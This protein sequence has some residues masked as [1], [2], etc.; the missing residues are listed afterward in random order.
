MLTARTVLNTNVATLA[1]MRAHLARVTNLSGNDIDE[2]ALGYFALGAVYGIS[3]DGALAQCLHETNNLHFGGQVSASQHNMA[4]I[5]ATNDGAAGLAWPTWRDGITAHYIHLLAWCGQPAGDADPRIREVKAAIR[6]L[7]KVITWRD[8]GGRWAVPGDGYA[9]AIERHWQ[10]IVNETGAA[11]V[12]TYADSP[13]PNYGYPRGEQTR[14]GRQVVAFVIHRMQGTMA[15]TRSWFQNPQSA[16]SSNWGIGKDGSIERYVPP[17]YSPWTNGDVQGPDRTLP[18]L[19]SALDAKIN[20]NEVTETIECEG[21]EGEPWPEAQYQA[22]LTVVRER[23]AARGITPSP[24]TVVGHYRIN[25]VTRAGCPGA[26]FPWGRLFADLAPAPPPASAGTAGDERTQ[27]LNDGNSLPV[28]ARGNLTR[29]GVA[30]LRAYGGGQEERVALYEKTRL[31]RLAG[32]TYAFLVDGPAS[33][34]ALMQA[35]K[36]VLY[37]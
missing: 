21:N 35:G 34:D 2:I 24:I 30:D 23:C 18:W 7:G 4:G 13:S 12:F 8:L 15:G 26:N 32:Q 5:G 33:Y 19:D 16:A 3:A 11:S 17:E 36:I 25:S 20:P 27:L 28:W 37:G 22:I 9:D 1:H 31:H 14:N 10:A 29:E 6:Q